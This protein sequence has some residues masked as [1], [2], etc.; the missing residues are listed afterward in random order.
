VNLSRVAVDPYASPERL[1]DLVGRCGELG[2][3]DVVLAWPRADGVFAGDERAFEAA[4]TAVVSAAVTS[5]CG[6][7]RTGARTGAAVGS[8]AGP[9][10]DGGRD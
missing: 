7:A 8:V 4:V 1:A 10:G 3:T 6:G 5:V 2:F 9:A